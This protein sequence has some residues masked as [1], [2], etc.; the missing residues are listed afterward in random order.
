ML[1]LIHRCRRYKAP[2]VVT[3]RN[4]GSAA[5][6]GALLATLHDSVL[7]MSDA[8]RLDL[9]R[10]PCLNPEGTKYKSTLFRMARVLNE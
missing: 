9:A 7:S 8:V 3:R 2:S 6:S 1:K 10:L 5:S 4:G